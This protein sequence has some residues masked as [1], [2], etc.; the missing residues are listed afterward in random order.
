MGEGS[1]KGI[2][3]MSAALE[4]EKQPL[5]KLSA[6]SYAATMNRRLG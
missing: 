5:L 2:M 4:L 6:K 1:E 3:W